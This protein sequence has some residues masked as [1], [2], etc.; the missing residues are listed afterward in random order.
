MSP[1]EWLIGRERATGDRPEF[2]P[3]SFAPTQATSR[4]G[5]TPPPSHYPSDSEDD[6]LEDDSNPSYQAGQPVPSPTQVTTGRTSR[7]R[8]RSRLVSGARTSTTEKDSSPAQSLDTDSTSRPGEVDA[9]RSHADAF[10]DDSQTE[11]GN[12]VQRQA[13]STSRTPG[14]TSGGSSTGTGTGTGT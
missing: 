6:Q 12:V 9:G 7:S 11:L 8:T 10:F 1:V 2:K 4:P 3:P 13:T 14:R 5:F